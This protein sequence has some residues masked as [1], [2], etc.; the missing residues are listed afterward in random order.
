MAAAVNRTIGFAFMATTYSPAPTMFG[1]TI[2]SGENGRKIN[3]PRRRYAE[4]GVF[5]SGILPR[6]RALQNCLKC[7]FQFAVFRLVQLAFEPLGFKRE[8]LVLECCQQCGP[9]ALSV[10][11]SRNRVLRHA[12]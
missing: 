10:Q 8:K 12:D 1:E 7:E 6:Q 5:G 9:S 4:S 3:S 2:Y 11:R